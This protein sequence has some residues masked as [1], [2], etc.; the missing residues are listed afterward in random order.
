MTYPPPTVS[1]SAA[2]ETIHIGEFSTLTWNSSYA[3]SCVIDQGIG[4]VAINGSVTLSPSETTTYTINA[5]GPGGTATASV[6]VTVIPLAISITS[7]LDGDTISRPDIMVQGTITNPLVNEVG[8][9]VNG[10][11]AMVYGNQ[12]VANHVPLQEGHN[13]I[14]ATVTDTD[15]NTATASITVN[16]T[17]T[18]DYIRITAN[19]ESG[20][21]PF[22]TTLIVEGSFIF[23]GPS[24]S[25]TGPGVAE[26]LDSP[27]DNEYNVRMTTEGIYYF[28]AEVTVDQSNIYTDTVAVILMNTTEIDNL[29]RSKW[30]SMSDSLSSG[31]IATAL[32]YISSG[33]RTSYQVMFD[34]LGDQLPSIVATKTEFNLIS[35]KNYMAEYELVTLENGKIYS[36]EVIF[37]RD[38][39][40][41]WMIREF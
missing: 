8:V 15:G 29:L 19:P 38:S 21:S 25:Y 11:V 16:A 35:L 33:A 18:A 10:I 24:L 3:D 40:G 37:I 41:L 12:F 22:E 30:R 34:A 5:T 7:P 20:V 9:V 6:T 26:F 28:T 2:P 23:T 31:D 17:V 39:N 14:T 13:I 27:N 36:Y 1:I 4:S 32:T